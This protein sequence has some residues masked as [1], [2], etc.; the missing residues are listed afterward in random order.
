MAIIAIVAL[1]IAVIESNYVDIRQ[2][3]SARLETIAAGRARDSAACLQHR[4][5]AA[6][7]VR[8]SPLMAELFDTWQQRGDRASL[9]LL[10]SP[11][12]EYG[13]ANEYHSVLIIDAMLAAAAFRS[14]ALHASSQAQL[15]TAAAELEQHV[16]NCD[17]A[18][19]LFVLR[20][21][22]TAEVSS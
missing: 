11:V 6:E 1:T 3:E 19:A 8:S 5:K 9:A 12:S 2:I 16:N 7:F 15:G 20:A 4:L 10:L 14:N 18:K 13:K 21:A 22:R 17:F